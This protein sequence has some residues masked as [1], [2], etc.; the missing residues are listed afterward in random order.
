M[1]VQ[2]DV[3]KKA[4]ESHPDC[5]WWVKGDRVDVVKG[6]KES[7]RGEW[8]GDADLND[9][10]LNALYQ[11]YKNQLKSA[12]SIGLGARSTL[13]FIEIDLH[14]A[15]TKITAYLTFLHSGKM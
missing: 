9:G 13:E 11:Q 15:Q 2:T 14:D 3:L 8:S 4:A 6:L 5:W 10:S 7:R 12:A 1:C